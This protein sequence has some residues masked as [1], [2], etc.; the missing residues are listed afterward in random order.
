MDANFTYVDP[1]F[2]IRMWMTNDPEL[3]ILQW[4]HKQGYSLADK[5][6]NLI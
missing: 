4:T 2:Y 5:I 6:E 1:I 3:Q